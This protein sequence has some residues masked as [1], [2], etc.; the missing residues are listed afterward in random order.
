MPDKRIQSKRKPDKRV[1]LDPASA[2]DWVQ[3]RWTF[4]RTITPHASVRGA[5]EVSPLAAG[6]SLYL[7]HAEVALT[8]G[9][10]LNGKQRYIYRRRDDGFDILFAETGLV[11]QSLH[12]KHGNDGLAATA[13]HQCLEDNYSSEYVLTAPDRMFVRHVVR[14]PFKDYVSATTFHRVH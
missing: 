11:F 6:Q 5:A 9:E 12:F 14:G 4:E 1:P 8:T 10:T 7:E 2:F 13:T 3:G